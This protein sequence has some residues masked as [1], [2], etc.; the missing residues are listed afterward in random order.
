MRLPGALRDA[1]PDTTGGSYPLVV[2]SHGY[3]LFRQASAFLMEQLASYGFVVIAGDHMDNWGS[4]FAAS[5][6][7]DYVIRPQEVADKIDFAETLSDADGEFPGLIDLEHV[8]VTGHSFGADTALLAGGSR[9]NTDVFLNEW[10]AMHPGDPVDPLND[11]PAMPEKL[12]EMISQ[13]GLAP[14]PRECGLI[15]QTHGLMLSHHW[16]LGR[17]TSVETVLPL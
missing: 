3:W 13:A 10:C 1:Q 4:I 5:Q 12:D 6:V 14:C 15:G 7:E 2:Y 11:C 17:S 16:P 9:L 8:G